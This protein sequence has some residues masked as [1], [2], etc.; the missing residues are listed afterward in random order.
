MYILQD[1]ILAL[2][3]RIQ[4]LFNFLLRDRLNNQTAL[5]RLF[6]MI[7]IMDYRLLKYLSINP[8]TL[9]QNYKA[10]FE[11]KPFNLSNL[12]LFLLIAILQ[13]QEH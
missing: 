4:L 13:D 5:V 8:L 6:L 12:L 7:L 3:V 1:L 2:V 10:N 11:F 9:F